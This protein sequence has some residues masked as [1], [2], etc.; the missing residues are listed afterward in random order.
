MKLEV[1]I[2]VNER[3][4][5]T[6]I[7]DEPKL[8]QALLQANAL[9]AYR[10]ECG[11][12]KSKNVVL[13]TKMAKEYQFVEFICDGCGARAQWGAYKKGGCFL[14]NWEKYEQK[15]PNTEEPPS[16]P[17]NDEMGF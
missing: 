16:A 15:P 14:K 11:L 10:G 13:Q 7:F 1:K 17:A 12:C 4:A 3:Q 6:V 9:L 8:S 5:V 2:Q